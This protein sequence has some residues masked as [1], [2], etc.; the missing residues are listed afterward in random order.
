MS[1]EKVASCTNGI[2]KRPRF[3]AKYNEQKAKREQ[4]AKEKN[5]AKSVKVSPFRSE[6]DI[7]AILEI[8]R[9]LDEQKAM[10]KSTS[11]VKTVSLQKRK[12]DFFSE[13]RALEKDI[14]ICKDL[15]ERKRLLQD[16]IEY[17]KYI[18]V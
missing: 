3:S 12:L 10:L 7:K 13:M 17:K 11:D 14:S 16:L 8:K 1:Y 6:E 9:K 15:A 5:A 4:L 2:L 18:K